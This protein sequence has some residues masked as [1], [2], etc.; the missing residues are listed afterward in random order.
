MQIISGMVTFVALGVLF[1]EVVCMQKRNRTVQIKGK[2][3]FVLY[4]ILVLLVVGGLPL[5]LQDGSTL[6]T[7]ALL[8]SATAAFASVAVR[9]GISAR[10]VEKFLYG[11][12]WQQ[13]QSLTLVGHQMH[14]MKLQ[15]QT[16]KRTHTL[17]FHKTSVKELLRMLQAQGFDVR[18]DGEIEKALQQYPEK[19]V[20]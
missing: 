4:A 5:L 8:F 17:Y 6:A 3:D 11:I 18:I 10:G 1:A 15:V 20:R 19:R 16:S 7:A 2:D 13:M 9:R 12:R 14:K